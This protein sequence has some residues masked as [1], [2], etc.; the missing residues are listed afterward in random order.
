MV[1]NDSHSTSGING[2]KFLSG[3]RPAFI[4]MLL[5]LVLTAAACISP[6]R[7]QESLESL[8]TPVQG[9]VAR[10]EDE[11][12]ESGARGIKW[13]TYWELCWDEYPAAVAYDVQTV[14]SEGI[15]PKLRRQTERCFR[16]QVASGVNDKSQ[17]LFNRDAVIAMQT[18]QLSYRVRAVLS[19]SRTSAWSDQIAVGEQR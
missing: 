13:S 5:L 4:K 10:L 19:D 16:M 7:N 15:S 11:V 17:G 2:A 3:L 6:S 18:S 12:S 14:T 8:S 1:T 9:F